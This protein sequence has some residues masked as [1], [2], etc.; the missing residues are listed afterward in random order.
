MTRGESVVMY[1][2]RE[3]IVQKGIIIF[4]TLFLFFQ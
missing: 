4:L 2:V 3:N 1:I